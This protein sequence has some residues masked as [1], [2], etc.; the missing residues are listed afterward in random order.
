MFAAVVVAGIATIG[1]AP[2]ATTTKK[3][4]ATIV[5]VKQ[6][7][8]TFTLTN[9]PT[10][11]QTL[12]AANVAVPS[13]FSEVSVVD[14][15][16]PAGKTWT[17]TPTVTATGIVIELRASGTKS[18]LAPTQFVAV[19]IGGTA[20]CA[21]KPYEWAMRVKQSNSFAGL[22][23]NDFD[24]PTPTVDVIGPPKTFEFATIES[25]QVVKETF[26]V[27][28]TAKDACANAAR[29][30]GSASLTGLATPAS[31]GTE[32]TYG[33]LAFV[34]AKG[35]P[36]AVATA[37]VKAV[38]SESFA[39]LT[40][41]N[42]ETPE[43]SAATGTSDWF[44]VVDRLCKPSDKTCDASDGKG[45]VVT[46]PVPPPGASTKLSLSGRGNSFTCGG[47]TYLN[48]G[49]HVTVDPDYP[50]TATA[51][52]EIAIEWSVAGAPS[53]SRIIC[54]TKDGATFVVPKCGRTPAVPC[55]LSRSRSGDILRATFLIAPAD[56]GWSLG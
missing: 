35:E 47:K 53:G 23:G 16:A 30:A 27:T 34:D 52:L 55:E 4:D 54:M 21:A 44:A 6:N 36:T 10:S 49:S 17:A 31:D 46:A 33:D 2:A 40:A 22:P 9:D 41:F 20:S 8:Y 28:V 56:P 5:Q 11:T 18:A 38:R 12:G 29:F 45:T 43:T 25:P 51:P 1:V 13:A 32:P 50:E 19:T 42:G 15:T 24:G 14:V 48:V 37:S 39:K 3:Y 7:E 26:Q